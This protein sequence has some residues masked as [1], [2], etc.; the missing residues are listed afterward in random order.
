MI[1]KGRFPMRELHKPSLRTFIWTTM[2]GIVGPPLLD[3]L[4]ALGRLT[5][6]MA[7]TNAISSARPQ[8]PAAKK[9]TTAA[10]QW[11]HSEERTL[12]PQE[13]ELLSRAQATL[14]GN[15]VASPAWAPY[16]GVEPSLGTYDGVWNWDS[17]FHAIAISHWDPTLAREQFDILFSRQLPSG[18]LPDVIWAKGGDVTTLTKPP[19]NGMGDCGGG[20]PL[21]RYA[22]PA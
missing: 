2:V 12:S 13:A 16:R 15:V 19:R 20:S 21:S 10:S 11:L 6:L 14:L 18:A 4:G 3:V 17:A 8:A 9:E 7:A 5:C 22:V 1:T